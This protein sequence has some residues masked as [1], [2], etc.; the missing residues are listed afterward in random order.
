M[1]QLQGGSTRG[2]YDW[3]NRI[4]VT[5]K[6]KKKIVENDLNQGFSAPKHVVTKKITYSGIQT[7]SKEINK[8]E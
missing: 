8:R 7:S 4:H 5:K 3:A 2:H 1:V 6:V